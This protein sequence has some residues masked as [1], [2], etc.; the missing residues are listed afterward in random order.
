M[1]AWH[2]RNNVPWKGS[3]LLEYVIKGLERASPGNAKQTRR[4]PVTT[5]MLE[6]LYQG[7]DQDNA[8]DVAVLATATVA[9]YG[10]LRL[11]EICAKREAYSTFNSKMHST[12]KDLHPPHTEAGSRVLVIPWTKV[13]RT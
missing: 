13:K 12:R 2:I 1:K 8:R 10:Q 6:Q 7:L 5:E 9:F 11:G 4:P 3:S